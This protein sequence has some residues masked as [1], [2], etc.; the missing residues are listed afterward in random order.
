MRIGTT[1]EDLGS[2]AESRLTANPALVDVCD[3]LHRNS[4]DSVCD[5]D[6]RGFGNDDAKVVAFFL[7]RNSKAKSLECVAV[8][9]IRGQDLLFWPGGHHGASALTTG[10]PWPHVQPGPQQHWGR[11][12][13][14]AGGGA[15]GERIPSRAQ[16]RLAQPRH[17]P[18][19]GP[20]HLLHG[21]CL[22]LWSNQI[23]DEGA[24]AI[25]ASLERNAGLRAI[26]CGHA[27]P[28]A[29]DLPVL[30]TAGGLRASEPGCMTT[31]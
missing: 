10:R 9:R 21:P 5:G 2:R 6:G 26:L 25:A 7:A 19:I 29:A 17:A 20:L 31:A 15:E 16:V 8:L 13:G 1:A 4:D 22:R 12:R 3:M 30:L 23:G 11:W 24:N 18:P 28:V 27:G 14:G